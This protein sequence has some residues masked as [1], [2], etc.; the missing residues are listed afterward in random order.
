[1]VVSVVSS[2][3]GVVGISWSR[4]PPDPRTKASLA[5]LEPVQSRCM[6]KLLFLNHLWQ[7]GYWTEDIAI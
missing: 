2:S 5:S 6:V 4:D 3:E 1:M 7:D